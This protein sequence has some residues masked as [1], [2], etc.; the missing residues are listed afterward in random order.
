MTEHF[1][2]LLN[3]FL[4]SAITDVN[5]GVLF[6]M[7]DQDSSLR[8]QFVAAVRTRQAAP[9]L[10]TLAAPSEAVSDRIFASVAQ[11]STTALG[12]WGHGR[13][14]LASAGVVALLGLSF[15]GGVQWAQQSIEFP[16]V[17]LMESIPDPVAT[18]VNHTSP[19]QVT[20]LDKTGVA[21]SSPGI[22]FGLV[23]RHPEAE[24]PSGPSAEQS[25]LVT[26]ISP[27]P[28]LSAQ[29]ISRAE[30]TSPLPERR[31]TREFEVVDGR[32]IAGTSDWHLQIRTLQVIGESFSGVASNDHSGFNN[33]A[34]DALYSI[35]DGLDVGLELGRQSFH[36]QY[37]QTRGGVVES[38]RQFPS[39]F[40]VG[41]TARF[42]MKDALAQD[43]SPYGQMALG[44]GDGGAIGRAMVGVTWRPVDRVSITSGLEAGR[45]WY[46]ANGAP[47]QTIHF[48]W[49]IGM[50]VSW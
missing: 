37:E 34:V 21:N 35:A 32:S 11:S 17:V 47:L 23:R 4:D 1:N 43:L 38:V 20:I 18:S 7:M 30:T 44:I 27:L 10:G 3:D 42:T 5:E 9:S 46:R 2:S 15:Y 6:S 8:E 26:E 29:R 13:I 24:L 28:R 39:L 36:Q 49:S 40:W 50:G 12:W 41:P 25:A 14:L 22:Q 33:L 16:Q 45:L 31:L 19:Q 48:N